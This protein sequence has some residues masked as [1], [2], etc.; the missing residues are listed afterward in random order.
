MHA[1]H[2][3]FFYLYIGYQ[4]NGMPPDSPAPAFLLAI[5]QQPLGGFSLNLSHVCSR[6]GKCFRIWCHNI[7]IDQRSHMTKNMFLKGCACL[8]YN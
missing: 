2:L 4:I 5:A 7:L 1:F 6:P 3:T 8:E